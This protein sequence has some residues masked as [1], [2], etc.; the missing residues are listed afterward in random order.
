MKNIFFK[1]GFLLLT[2]AAFLV[3]GFF[4]AN[5]V[6]AS[7]TVTPAT[8]G[9]A[10]SADTTGGSYTALTGPVIAEGAV[11]DIG[12]AGTDTIIL[13]APSGFE[14]DIGGSPR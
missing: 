1:K 9:N 14:F 3:G 2:A 6:F 11:G 13:N 4:V 8:G 7:V 12:T 5:N 10:I